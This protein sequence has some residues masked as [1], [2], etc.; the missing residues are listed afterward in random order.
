LR[1]DSGATVSHRDEHAHRVVQ[2]FRY[3]RQFAG[4]VIDPTQVQL[5]QLLLNLM[6]NGIDPPPGPAD[7]WPGRSAAPPDAWLA[8]CSLTVPSRE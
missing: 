1:A 7:R 3:D 2:L 4:P 6:I 5:Q 8:L